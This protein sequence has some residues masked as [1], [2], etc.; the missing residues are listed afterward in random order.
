MIRLV[1]IGVLVSQAA[2]GGQSCEARPATPVEVA[3]A[4]DAA[5][6]IFDSLERS[7]DSVA[8]VARSGTNLE[9][10]G[11]RYSHAALVV[12]DHPAGPW[13]VVHMLN[14]CGSGESSLFDQGLVNFFLDDLYRLDAVV[15]HLAEPMQRQL[16]TVLDQ[17]AASAL[18]QPRYNMV[19]HPFSATYQ[20]SNQWLLELIALAMREE[21]LAGSS[22][23][24]RALAWD[25]LRE[26]RFEPDRIR[27]GRL[28]R[29]AGALTQANLS[30]LHHPLRSR[31]AGRYE[32]VTVRAIARYLDR[33][34]LVTARVEFSG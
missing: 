17:G 14:H 28:K 3:A 32:L 13:T 18:H 23:A 31:I 21:A 11:L 1:L 16:L 4:A 5:Y 12:R 15:L 20:N 8:L 34:D 27:I 7:G 6:R 2:F 24:T 25:V 10:Y 22:T 19:A 30:F 26:T 29:F 33:Q 9:E